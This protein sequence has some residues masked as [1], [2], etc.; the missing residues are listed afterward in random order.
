MHPN[1]EAFPR[2]ATMYPDGQIIDG[3]ATGMDIRT[4]AAIHI[5]AGMRA[6]TWDVEHAVN[7]ADALLAKLNE[8]GEQ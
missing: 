3:P 5:L 8:K 2:P 6:N 4:Y 1:D 7:L